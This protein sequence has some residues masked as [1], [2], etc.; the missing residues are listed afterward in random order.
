MGWSLNLYENRRVREAKAQRVEMKVAMYAM[1]LSDEYA[2]ATVERYVNDLHA[3][4]AELNDGRRYDELGQTFFRVRVLIKVFKRRNPGV[5]HAKRPFQPQYFR[6]IVVGMGWDRMLLQVARI[7]TSAE[8]AMEGQRYKAKPNR[9]FVSYALATLAGEHAFRLAEL[10]R[11]RVP[12]VTI[13]HWMMVGD[14][15]MYAGKRLVRFLDSG[16]PDPQDRWEYTH[17]VS[18]V[19]PSKTDGVGGKLTVVS[20]APKDPAHAI[21]AWATV[22]WALLSMNPV[23]R[24]YAS[25]TP[26]FTEEPFRPGG[27]VEALKESSF[28]AAMKV[29]CRTAKPEIQYTGL[30][31]HCFRVYA[32]NMAVR[33]GASPMLVAAL[34]RWQSDCFLLYGRDHT[35]ALEG[36]AKRM[37][38]AKA[39]ASSAGDGLTEQIST[40]EERKS[41]PP[42]TKKTKRE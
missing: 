38:V 32:M 1:Y 21:F 10:V 6:Q 8:A 19:G 30:G 2:S 28:W 40:T 7:K 12:S 31:N 4:Q 23:P 29:M 22:L 37:V 36:L 15:V 9:L 41:V 20:Y 5:T 25:S 39:V 3:F 11:T 35:E 33:M 14:W 13:R 24:R 16:A 26:V 42:A 18:R 17:C 34:G 27:R